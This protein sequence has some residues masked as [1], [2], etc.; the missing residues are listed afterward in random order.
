MG[1]REGGWR[2]RERGAGRQ[3]DRQK[4][5]QKERHRQTDRH[6]RHRLTDMQAEES[7]DRKTQTDEQVDRHGRYRLTNMQAEERRERK[8]QTHGRTNRPFDRQAGKQSNRIKQCASLPTVS[9]TMWRTDIRCNV[10]LSSPPGQTS[11]SKSQ[12]NAVSNP[13]PNPIPIA[14]G[15][16]RG[17]GL[18][19]MHVL[20]R[21]WVRLDLAS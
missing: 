3:T 6:G 14:G 15:Y 4:K 18:E 21:V 17:G 20:L 7:G 2:E 8:T 10:L 5:R 1:E 19:L 13:K 9:A 11:N 16:A 12:S